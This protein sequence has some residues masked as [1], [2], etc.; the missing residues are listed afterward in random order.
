MFMS[1]MLQQ[2]YEF[3]S[4]PVISDAYIYPDTMDST[5]AEM[6]FYPLN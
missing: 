6:Y 1:Y 5:L 3:S 4:L 2:N